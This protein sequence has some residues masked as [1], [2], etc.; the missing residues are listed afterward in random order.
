MKKLIILVALILALLESSTALAADPPLPN[1]PNEDVFSCCVA[2]NTAEQEFLAGGVWRWRFN[3]NPSCAGATSM[4]RYYIDTLD[5]ISQETNTLVMYDPAAG[6]TLYVNCGADFSAICGT[7]AAACLGRRYPTNVDIDISNTVLTYFSDSIRAV[8]RHELLHAM[9]TWNEQYCYT[10]GCL[11]TLTCVANWI[12]FMNC[13][14]D[15]RHG[16]TYIERERWARTVDPCYHKSCAAGVGANEGGVY[17]WWENSTPQTRVALMACHLDGHGGC[18]GYRWT[19]IQLPVTGHYQGY[20]VDNYAPLLRQGEAICIN[21]ENA[22]NTVLGRN[23]F[24]Y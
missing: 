3:T 1:Q 7:G 21:R 12:D 19:G 6:H 2:Y 23:D 16:F 10:G 8:I 13:G 17:I 4:L 18:D 5:D 22:L 9:L 15:S 11:N 20:H 14:P 24:C